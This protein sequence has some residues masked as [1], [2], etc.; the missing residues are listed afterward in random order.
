MRRSQHTNRQYDTTYVKNNEK[1][2]EVLQERPGKTATKLMAKAIARRE[3][4]V[5]VSAQD[6]LSVFDSAQRRYFL[7]HL[8]PVEIKKKRTSHT[9]GSEGHNH[10]DHPRESGDTSRGGP[11]KLMTRPGQSHQHA[12]HSRDQIFLFK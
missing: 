6:A 8:R 3:T 4:Q 10:V 2:N 5:K 9:G 7:V 1:T 12:N 11:E